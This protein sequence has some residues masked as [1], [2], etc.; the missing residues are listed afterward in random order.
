M[1]EQK[2]NGQEAADGEGQPRK[3][4]LAEA[5][6]RKLAQNKQNQAKEQAQ[7]KLQKNNQMIKSQNVK[8]PNNQRRKTGGS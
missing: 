7:T 8:K 5:M 3:I 6:K 2:V 1:S 4:S